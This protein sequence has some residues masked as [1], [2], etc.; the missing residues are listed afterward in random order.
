MLP[1]G[2]T[3]C[4]AADW[5]GCRLALLR[6]LLALPLRAAQQSVNAGDQDA[7]FE[8]FGQIVIGTGGKAFEHIF[9]TRTRRE[10][11]DGNEVARRTQAVRDLKAIRLLAA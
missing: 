8:G 2:G 10:H 9:R 1:D 11:E 7:E 5:C 3:A 6:G 4:F